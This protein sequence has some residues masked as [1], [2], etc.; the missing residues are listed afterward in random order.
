L[1]IGGSGSLSSRSDIFGTI[2]SH[3]SI[4]NSAGDNAY[5]GTDLASQYSQINGAHAWSN[6]PSGTAGN[7]ITFTERMRIDTSGNFMVGTST[8]DVFGRFD[9]RYATLAATGATDNIALN[10]S[11]GAT[12][13]RGAQIYMGTGSTRHFTIG[14]N[15][16]DSY[17]GTS[18]NKPLRFLT[19]DVER[20]RITASGVLELTQGQIKF[21]AT[22]VAS[23]DAN[24]LDD[25]EE[26]TFDFGIAFGGS[27]VGVTYNTRQGAYTKIGRQVTVTGQLALTSK[28]AQVGDATITG[29]P[30]TVGAGARFQ[31]GVCFGLI[32]AITFAD[33]LTARFQSNSAI[34]AFLET[35][36]AGVNSS[37][38]NADFAN[39][40]QID[41]SLTYFTS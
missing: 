40:S 29:L 30:F 39:D 36:N 11:S 20:M 31:G 18:S 24:T 32:Y 35:T 1:Q 16:D 27:S 12:A 21:P 8:A 4:I 38:T 22:Q 26:G 15:N 13:S 33:V 19:N 34:C 7:A 37:L 41:F 6:A 10:I 17:L 23:A 25:Y 9:D 2:F 3:N 28:G 5:I 14:A